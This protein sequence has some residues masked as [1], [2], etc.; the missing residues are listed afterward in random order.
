LAVWEG[1]TSTVR[2]RTRERNFENERAAARQD[3]RQLT[4]AK[5][6][7][8]AGALLVR[9][10]IRAADP[11]SVPQQQALADLLDAAVKAE[12]AGEIVAEPGTPRGDEQATYSFGGR[13][14]GCG[15]KLRRKFIALA[16]EDVTN[17]S[18]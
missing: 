2:W 16:Q 6:V 12:A 9:L 18:E 14:R 3:L 10:Q 4:Y 5:Y 8:A 15:G 17:V 11:E 1:L 13:G 7:Q